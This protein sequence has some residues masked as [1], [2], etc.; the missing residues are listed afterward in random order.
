MLRIFF[1]TFIYFP[2]SV[3]LSIVA[4][5][6]SIIK[7][8]YETVRTLD[9]K[10]GYAFYIFMFSFSLTYIFSEFIATASTSHLLTVL[11]S[12]YAIVCLA[13]AIYNTYDLECA[14]PLRDIQKCFTRSETLFSYNNLDASLDNLEPC[15]LDDNIIRHSL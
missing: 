9:F 4:L 7:S 5:P 1:K 2:I 8:L 10:K 11:L 15:D 12:C 13:V 6:Y 3:I 14:S